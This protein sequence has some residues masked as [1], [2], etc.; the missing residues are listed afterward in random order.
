MYGQGSGLDPAHVEQVRDEV[1]ET[2]GM[3]DDCPEE[4]LA[5]LGRELDIGLAEGRRGDCYGGQRVPQVMSHRRQQAGAQLVDPGQLLR[6][7]CLLGESPCPPQLADRQRPGAEHPAILAEVLGADELQAE[8]LPGWHLDC[9]VALMGSPDR[10]ERPP[11]TPER[12]RV[13][14][15]HLERLGEHALDR[16]P[17]RSSGSELGDPGRFD[18]MTFHP[19][20]PPGR[21][22]RD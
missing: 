16:V 22:L 4:L 14:L 20:P 12:G 5:V 15:V 13:H 7:P 18:A 8:T 10:Y 2:G 6:T 19:R 3:L 1:V 9:R 11:V 17:F 21:A